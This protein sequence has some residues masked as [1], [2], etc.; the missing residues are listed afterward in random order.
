MAQ[1][2]DQLQ[3]RIE[4]VEAAIN[5]LSTAINHLVHKKQLLS[6]TNIRQSEINDLQT[7]IISLESQIKIL[8]SQ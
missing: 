8:Q 3:V 1:S 6:L 4:A 2:N 7:K 5:D